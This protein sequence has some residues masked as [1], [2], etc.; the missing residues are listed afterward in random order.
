MGYLIR[1]SGVSV[2][3]VMS[4]LTCEVNNYMV[5]SYR[6]IIIINNTATRRTNKAYGIVMH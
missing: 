4:M 6:D 1:D 5:R 2:A 3:A